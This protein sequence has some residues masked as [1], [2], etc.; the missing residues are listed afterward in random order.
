MSIYLFL[1]A[2][3]IVTLKEI[4]MYLGKTLFKKYYLNLDVFQKNKKAIL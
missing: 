1:I 4:I 3:L 2:K